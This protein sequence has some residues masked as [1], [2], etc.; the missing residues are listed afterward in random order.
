MVS[1]ECHV[2]DHAAAD[3][4]TIAAPLLASLSVCRIH[5]FLHAYTMYLRVRIQLAHCTPTVAA[6]GTQE[7]DVHATEM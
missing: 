6:S 4:L 7:R 2:G 3:K 5:C 1:G